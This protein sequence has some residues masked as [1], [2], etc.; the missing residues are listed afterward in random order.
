MTEDKD[1]KYAMSVKRMLETL[2]LNYVKVDGLLSADNRF[3]T[4]MVSAYPQLDVYEPDMQDF[5]FC[6]IDEFQIFI[7]DADEENVDEARSSFG[8]AFFVWSG[9]L[10]VYALVVP[11]KD[12]IDKVYTASKIPFGTATE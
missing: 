11:S 8:W 7:T 6:D 12:P 10:K 2:G 3:Y 4:N 9:L 5:T 1:F